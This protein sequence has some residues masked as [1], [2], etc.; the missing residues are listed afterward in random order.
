[1]IHWV[2]TAPNPRRPAT[3]FDAGQTGWKLHAVEA[4]AHATFDAVRTRTAA[5]GL[6][7]RHGWGLDMF[8]EDKCAR[9]LRKVGGPR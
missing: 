4:E 9:C 7:A 1:M 6:R 8:I 3:G 5:C 2:T